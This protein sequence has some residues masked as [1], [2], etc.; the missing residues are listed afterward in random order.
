MTKNTGHSLP[1]QSIL[2]STIGFDDFFNDFIGHATSSSYP[3]HNVVKY[4]RDSNGVITENTVIEIA[5]AGFK[6]TD[7]K[8]EIENGLLQISGEIS[9][10][11]LDNAVTKSY[12]HKGISS[13]P[14]IKKFKVSDDVEI[15]SADFNDGILTVNLHKIS[16]IINKKVIEIR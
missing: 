16:P 15:D 3:P 11:P 4:T 9:E 8:I 13:R 2:Q 7:L 1:F 12:L 5:L 14:F 6:K 10:E